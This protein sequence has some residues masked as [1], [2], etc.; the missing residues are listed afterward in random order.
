[1]S[2]FYKSQSLQQKVMLSA[3]DG[4]GY[5]SESLT[6]DLMKALLPAL[7]HPS[8]EQEPAILSFARGRQGNECWQCES[9]AQEQQRLAE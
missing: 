2:T 3:I 5:M 4:T 9:F 1:M 6:V 8:L 7:S